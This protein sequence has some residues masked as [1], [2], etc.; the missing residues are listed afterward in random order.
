MWHEQIR[1]RAVIMY[2]VYGLYL[3]EIELYLG[4]SQRSIRRWIDLFTAKGVVM[5]NANA[6]R[7]SRY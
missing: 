6:R 2:L 4:A 1:W 7:T 3:N 5:E